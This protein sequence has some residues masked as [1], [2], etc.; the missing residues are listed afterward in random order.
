MHASYTETMS[1]A[2]IPPSEVYESSVL[3]GIR[4]DVEGLW[5]QLDAEL[6]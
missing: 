2:V 1:V 4:L 5:R 3:P 6:A